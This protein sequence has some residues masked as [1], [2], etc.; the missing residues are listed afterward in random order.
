MLLLLLIINFVLCSFYS[1]SYSGSY[2]R[3]SRRIELGFVENW[4]PVKTQADYVITEIHSIGKYFPNYVRFEIDIIQL[5]ND[6]LPTFIKKKSTLLLKF[7]ELCKDGSCKIEFI[8]SGF[9][10]EKDGKTKKNFEKFHFYFPIKENG[11][12]TKEEDRDE[13]NIKLDRFISVILKMGR[14]IFI[15]LETLD[16][17]LIGFTKPDE[18][19]RLL[20]SKRVIEKIYTLKNIRIKN[21]KLSQNFDG[22]KIILNNYREIELLQAVSVGFV[23]EKPIDNKKV[24][25]YL[26]EEFPGVCK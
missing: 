9:I 24:P 21:L 19:D 7:V 1:G 16:Y 4:K 11:T 12:K 23:N 15:K 22:E 13:M 8:K 26:C 25:D 20:D 6:D 5:K 17:V 3:K 10:L 2:G 14:N 18:V